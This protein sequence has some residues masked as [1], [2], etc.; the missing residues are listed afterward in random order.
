[1]VIRAGAENTY[2]QRYGAEWADACHKNLS[3]VSVEIHL[4]N[5]SESVFYDAEKHCDRVSWTETNLDPV[6]YSTYARFIFTNKS[7]PVLWCDI[8]GRPT[9]DMCEVD[10][11]LLIK[12][13]PVLRF[14]RFKQGS[15]HEGFWLFG[16]QNPNIIEGV[17]QTTLE[18]I[19]TDFRWGT[20]VRVN[21]YLDQYTQHRVNDVCG[22]KW[23]FLTPYDKRIK[24]TF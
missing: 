3:N 11:E 19:Q 6:V 22:S 23:Q 12:V 21:R 15:W 17:E 16:T 18:T 1:M 9:S 13:S 24:E 4:V 8:D 2:W 5:P 14:T 20:D 7:E 10:L